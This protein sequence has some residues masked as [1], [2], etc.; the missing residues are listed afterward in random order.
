[1][2]RRLGSLMVCAVSSV[3]WIGGCPQADVCDAGNPLALL[4]AVNK[5][6]NCGLGELTACELRV[7]VTTAGQISPDVDI[8]ITQEQAQA[9]I[10]FIRANNLKCIA[11]IQE[12]IIRAQNDPDSIQIPDSL[13]QL[14]ESGVDLGAL[15]RQQ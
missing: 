13:R 15:V 8:F 6:A 7:L 9:A 3:V 14:I 1:M 10:D 4:S 11:D 2:S 12:L 5:F